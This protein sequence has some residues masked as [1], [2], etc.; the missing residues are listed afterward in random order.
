MLY[1]VIAGC[2]LLAAALLIL[3]A[4]RTLLKGHWVLGWVRGMFGLCLALSA[5]LLVFVAL[6]FYSYHQLGKEETIASIGFSRIDQQ[7]YKV[8]LV[9]SNGVEQ[10]YELAGDLWQLDARIL[11]WNKTLAGIGMRP[12]YRLDR[13]SGR[14]YALEKEKNAERTVYSLAQDNQIDVWQWLQD[15][16]SSGS[17]VDASYGSATYLP[18][19]DGAL[20]TVSLTN[21]GLIARPLNDRAKAAVA[22]WQ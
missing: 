4:G 10:Y 17:I 8:S 14:Y 22:N 20:F 21:S 12:G 7:R 9:D 16:S 5:V 15:Y 2:V 19:E 3:F 18:M 13:L 6:D 1:T 11:K